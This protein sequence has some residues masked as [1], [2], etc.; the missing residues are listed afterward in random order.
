MYLDNTWVK[1]QNK[2]GNSKSQ[3]D[4]SHRGQNKCAISIY[5]SYHTFFSMTTQANKQKL[6]ISNGIQRIFISDNIYSF[7][8]SL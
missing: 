7:V 8:V 4:C 1:S 5:S 6:K 2:F 3:L